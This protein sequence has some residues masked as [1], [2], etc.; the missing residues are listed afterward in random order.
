MMSRSNSANIGSCAANVG[1][2]ASENGAIAVIVAIALTAI[3]G[4]GA[5]AIDLGRAWNLDTELQNAADAVARSSREG[6]H[7]G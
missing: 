2:V 4:M 7:A 6:T 5:L 3:L 1:F